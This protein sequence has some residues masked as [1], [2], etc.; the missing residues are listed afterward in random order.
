MSTKSNSLHTAC[1]HLLEE[2]TN[3]STL[4]D[5][6]AKRLVFYTEAERINQ[7]L[8]ST[9][10]SVNSE[11]FV[12]LL[13]RVDECYM[14]VLDHVSRKDQYFHVMFKI[15]LQR[16]HFGIF[17]P[18]YKQS[19]VYRVKY[20]ACLSRALGLIRSYVKSTLDMAT[21]AA[22]PPPGKI[23]QPVYF[24]LN[25]DFFWKMLYR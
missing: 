12:G 8:Q 9:T 14:Y 7:K 5:Q 11:T 3:L 18:T 24:L 25:L 15:S 4:S 2:Q 10:L 21:L 22:A 20:Q 16:K 19:G 13:E 23:F 17:Q 1:Q 6:L